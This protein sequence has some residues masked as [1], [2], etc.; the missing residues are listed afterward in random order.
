MVKLFGALCEQTHQLAVQLSV[1]K[2]SI[3]W[4]VAIHCSALLMTAV[5]E[6]LIYESHLD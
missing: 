6:H 1:D 4:Q 2:D 5:S 3:V